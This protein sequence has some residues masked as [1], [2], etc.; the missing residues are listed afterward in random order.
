MFIQL[1]LPKPSIL[2]WQDLWAHHLSFFPWCGD[3]YAAHLR[4]DGRWRVEKST[5]ISRSAAFHV[6]EGSVQSFAFGGVH[7]DLS[8]ISKAHNWTSLDRCFSTSFLQ[9]Q[10]WR[11]SIIF[12]SALRHW[13]KKIK[14]L[15]DTK[16]VDMCWCDSLSAK[17]LSTARPAQCSLLQR[18]PSLWQ[19]C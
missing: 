15:K 3:R 5:S 7:E 18:I 13:Q 2:V 9:F 14:K 11:S 6:F 19:I 8:R 12:T 1:V 10:P 4:Q 17:S 16:G